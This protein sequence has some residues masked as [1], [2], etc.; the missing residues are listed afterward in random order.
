MVKKC[1]SQ[2]HPKSYN[3]RIIYVLSQYATV[4]KISQLVSRS[5]LPL[6]RTCY[7]RFCH[8]ERPAVTPQRGASLSSRGWQACHGRLEEKGVSHS[9]V[10][11]NPFLL[12]EHYEK[13]FPLTCCLACVLP[14][15]M[16][17]AVSSGGPAGRMHRARAVSLQPGT[18]EKA[19]CRW[20]RAKPWEWGA[21][22]SW[23]EPSAAAVPVDNTTCMVFSMLRI[24]ARKSQQ[25]SGHVNRKAGEQ[26][27]QLE[28]K[29][30]I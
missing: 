23:V 22:N 25:V 19:C 4:L 14:L 21:R 16:W 15:K 2:Q 8:R 29:Q 24:R 10:H 18:G 5:F 6:K 13:P 12:W 30:V 20:M 3:H 11:T 1:F 7:G 17:A 26:N 27:V 28:H 9:T